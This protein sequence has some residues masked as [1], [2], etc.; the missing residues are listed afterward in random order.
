[1]RAELQKRTSEHWSA[2]SMADEGTV[3]LVKFPNLSLQQHNRRIPTAREGWNEVGLSW[4]LSPDLLYIDLCVLVS[5]LRFQGGLKR[6]VEY[7]FH[8]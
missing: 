1:M 7:T 5:C 3:Q 8:P 2:A 4:G 6:G